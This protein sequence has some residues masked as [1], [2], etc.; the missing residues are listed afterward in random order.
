MKRP[1]GETSKTR[2]TMLEPSLAA[3]AL[4][5]TAVIQETVTS[6]FTSTPPY[7]WA[8]NLLIIG[9]T[10]LSGRFPRTSAVMTTAALLATLATPPPFASVAPLA[11][12]INILSA[13]GRNIRH[14]LTICAALSVAIFISLVIQPEGFP[15]TIGTSLSTVV[16]IGLAV[17]G[18]VL[19]RN[20]E[21]RL[22][23]QR[24]ASRQQLLDLRLELA[25][26]LH[27]TVAQSLSHIAMRAWMALEEPGLPEDTRHALANIAQDASLS[28]ADLRQLLS[29]LRE[30]SPSTGPTEL[31]ADVEALRGQLAEQAERLSSAG[32][33][34]EVTVRLGTVS[35]A[36]AVTLSKT[37]VEIVNN[38]LKHALPGGR[39]TLSLVETGSLIVGTFSNPIPQGHKQGKGLGMVGMTERLHLLQGTLDLTVK[40]GLWSVRVTLPRIV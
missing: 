23:L 36:Q 38:M 1:P 8:L 28:A 35:K 11:A 31:L 34:P 12:L 29:T 20:S 9:S 4:V 27:D 18:G 37:V 14:G 10:A 19:W 17:L 3:V 24:A 2:L 7:V 13:L 39:C 30:D 15:P 16:I 6:E 40:D 21:E 5:V 33:T 25:R 26:D 22:V 32:F